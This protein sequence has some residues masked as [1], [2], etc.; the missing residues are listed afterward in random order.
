MHAPPLPPATPS[1][2]C[3][4]GTRRPRALLHSPPTAKDSAATQM[5]S[6]PARARTQPKAALIVRVDRT[7]QREVPT[8]RVA[9]RKPHTAAGACAWP[10]WCH[11][12]WWSARTHLRSRG[13]RPQICGTKLTRKKACHHAAW[14]P[15]S[16]AQTRHAGIHTPEVQ[17]HPSARPHRCPPRAARPPASPRC[18]AASPSFAR[19]SLLP[20]LLLFPSSSGPSGA[21]RAS[22]ST[23]QGQGG[24][25][26]TPLQLGAAASLLRGF[27]GDEGDEGRPGGCGAGEG[28][29]EGGGGGGGM[30]PRLPRHAVEHAGKAP[31]FLAASGVNAF[32][33]GTWPAPV[34]QAQ[35]HL[36]PRS[37]L[38]GP[39]STPMQG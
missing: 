27:G 1:R 4:L 34:A 16:A 10:S 26:T 24:C 5:H 2:T 28:G 36:R 11:G 38:R 3:I 37:C 14:V 18:P 39:S 13:R 33:A 22:A 29:G 21:M 25:G 19:G 32:S 7:D 6:S 12:G 9:A 35:R 15:P 20:L 8:S 31:A 17:H 23:G 30:E